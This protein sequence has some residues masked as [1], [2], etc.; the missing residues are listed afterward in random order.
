MFWLKNLLPYFILLC[1]YL[2]I[3]EI[4]N[5]TFR[6]LL[7]LDKAQISCRRHYV[8]LL[9]V[10]KV[11]YTFQSKESISV[12]ILYCYIIPQDIFRE[13]LML[14]YYLTEDCQYILNCLQ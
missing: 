2:G 3:D 5:Q 1:V 7:L 9:R 14:L 13:I 11:I 12:R 6:F 8:K 10:V 4:K